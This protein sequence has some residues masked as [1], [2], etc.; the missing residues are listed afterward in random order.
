[1]ILR[2]WRCPVPHDQVTPFQTFMQET[3]FPAL[4]EHD[5]CHGMTTAVDRSGDEASILAISVWTNREALEAFTE[6]ESDGVLFEEAK[7]FLGGEPTVEHLDVLD[8]T[9]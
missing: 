9:L 5:G 4:D 6:R 7:A 1:M 3:L 2:V 8:H